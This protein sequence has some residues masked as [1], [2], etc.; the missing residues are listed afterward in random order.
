MTV[1]V[2]N[3]RRNTAKTV[4]VGSAATNGLKYTAFKVTLPKGRYTFY[5]SATDEWGNT[6]AKSARNTL[7][8]K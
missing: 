8:V 3:S 1:V 4:V 7:A 2:K 6:S 5:V